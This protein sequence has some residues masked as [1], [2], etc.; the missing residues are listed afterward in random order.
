M[1]YISRMSDTH[2]HIR[3]AATVLAILFV[4]QAAHATAG[5]AAPWRLSGVEGLPARLAL[6][7]H[8][9]I[10]YEALDGQ[11]RS[12]YAGRDQLLALRT[13]LKAT[14]ALDGL[15]LTAEIMDSRQALADDG[16]PLGTSMVNTL[17]ML[18]AH[19]SVDLGLRGCL[20]AGRHT[21]DLGSR[22]LVAR[23]RYRNTINNFTGLNGTWTGSAGQTVRAFFVLPVDRLPSERARLRDNEVQIDR[24]DWDVRFWGVHAARPGVLADAAGELYLFGLH[25]SDTPARPTRNR[26]L[27]TFGGR[28]DRKHAPACCDF[29][30]EAALQFGESRAS[31]SDAD[32]T[33]LDHAAHFLHLAGGYTFDRAWA[34][35]VV[36]QFDLASGDTDPSDAENNRFDTLYGAR[37]F[38]YGPTGIYGVFARANIVSPGWRVIVKPRRAL[39]VMLAHRF[40]WL[41][42]ARDAWTT[43]GVRDAS[44]DAGRFVGHQ[45]EIRVRWEAMPGN[46]R[47]EGGV[48]RL[49]A[50]GFLDD[51]PNANGE[52]D[53]TYAYLQSILTF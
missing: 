50:G 11:F 19:L 15:A 16:T 33:D 22:R 34:P 28:L 40:Y 13:A 26:R 46:L 20:L 52:G 7:G 21:M 41:D 49:F 30:L 51:A 1:T 10:R 37:R 47:L 8:Q 27:L 9:R 36:L 12:A 6:S 48:A 4:L 44:G 39:N 18:Q 32:V 38:E 45:A 3:P 42:S 5:D 2:R 31:L 23:N 53:A 43:A 35:R 25:E 17:E 29:E 14:V 24:E